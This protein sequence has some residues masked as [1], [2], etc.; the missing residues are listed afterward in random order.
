M[1][2]TKRTRLNEL[3]P[4]PVDCTLNPGPYTRSDHIHDP[5]KMTQERKSITS[6]PTAN[7][8]VDR[9]LRACVELLERELSYHD[10]RLPNNDL[11]KEREDLLTELENKLLHALTLLEKSTQA[12]IIYAQELAL[13]RVSNEL[14]R[15]DL[16]AADSALRALTTPVSDEKL[17]LKSAALL[18]SEGD[19]ETVVNADRVSVT[20]TIDAL[21]AGLR[22]VIEYYNVE[23]A[24]K[25][26]VS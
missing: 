16:H 5:R 8:E 21:K 6:R 12:N 19:G 22:E 10:G 4:I 26:L 11:P 9:S 1:K 23:L 14:M 17:L 25:A 20:F 3:R 15:Q 2:N 7:E 13:T 18:I 24:N